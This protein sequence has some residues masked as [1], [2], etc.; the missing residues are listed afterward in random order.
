MSPAGYRVADFLRSGGIMTV[1]FLVVSQ[2]VMML[3]Y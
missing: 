1:I 2:S 3:V